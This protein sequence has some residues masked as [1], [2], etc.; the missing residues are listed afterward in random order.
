MSREMSS[1]HYQTP[2][3]AANNCSPVYAVPIEVCAV[4]VIVVV[5]VVVAVSADV[6]VI[7][8][9]AAAS[10][11]DTFSDTYSTPPGCKIYF[12]S[13]GSHK[14]RYYH[15]AVPRCTVVNDSESGE[16]GCR[17]L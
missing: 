7:D 9:Y 15:H 4:V 12:L 2:P 5:V 3:L 10:L 16:A 13:Q 11:V 6:V 1:P 8:F 14:S 17:Q